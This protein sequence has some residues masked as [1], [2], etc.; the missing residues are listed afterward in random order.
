[1]TLRYAPASRPNPD[2]SLD[3]SG[4]LAAGL[5][6]AGLAFALIDAARAGWQSAT[7]IAAS[8]ASI[9]SGAV[10]VAIEARAAA[11]MLPLSLFGSRAFTAASASGVLVNFAYYGLIFAFSL[12]FQWRYRFSPQETGLAFLPMTLVLMVASIAGGRLVT[13]LGA[14]RLMVFGQALA[15]AGYLLLVP[16]LDSDSYAMLV[17]PMLLAATGTALTVPTM[18]NLAL[19]S[20]EGSRAGIASGVLNTARQI[21]GMLGVTVCGYQVR[22]LAEPSFTQGL[23][24]S[25]FIAVL[26]LSAGALLCHVALRES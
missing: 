4:Q 23:R 1:M 18:V 15:A 7:F 21:G 5:S 8:C 11:P 2:R 14:R 16:A 19:S 10:F 26:L 13:R 6:L 17:V 9:A 12:F 3:L 22:S 24:G 25:L 20:V